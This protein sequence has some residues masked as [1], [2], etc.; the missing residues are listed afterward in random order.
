[1]NE[2]LFFIILGFAAQLI[3]GALGLAYGVIN[4][5]VLLGMGI[6]PTAASAA[7]HTA[8]IFT[9]GFSGAS[10]LAFKNVD[11]RL[12]KRLIIPGVIGS[13]IG[14]FLLTKIPEKTIK[15][16][17]SAYLLIM[18]CMILYKAFKEAAWFEKVRHLINKA[19]DR[20]KPSHKPQRVIP[21]GLA[22][23]FCDAIGGGGWGAIVSSSLLAQ[24]ANDPHYTIGTTNLAEFLIAL[25]SSIVFFTAIGITHW[26]I[27]LGLILG[28]I[29]AAPLAAIAVRKLP[30]KVVMICAGS[31]IC[32]ISTY[33]ITKHFF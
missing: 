5:T 14:A 6:S 17:I 25:S 28:G 13:V 8:E 33:T 26:K 2:I 12:F 16:Y 3:D 24:D 10:H 11:F 18:G 20:E 1:M 23:G 27:V 29:F 21:L 30:A 7:I 15:P 31:L 19:L 32:I 4:M 22:G 9:T